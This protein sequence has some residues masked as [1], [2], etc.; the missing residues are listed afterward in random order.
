MASSNGTVST[1][2]VSCLRSFKN[3]LAPIKESSFATIEVPLIRWEDELGRLRVLAANMG[4]HQTGQ[5]SLDFRL[6]DASHISKLIIKLLDGLETTI[7]DVKVVL[8]EGNA[9]GNNPEMY[10]SVEDDSSTELQ[11]LHG[12]ILTII[13]ELFQTS[14][15]IRKPARHDFMTK[16]RLDDVKAFEPF[17]WEHVRN[18]LPEAD[19]EIIQ[20]VGYAITRR[21]G[22]LKYRERHHAKLGKGLS[23][24]GDQSEMSETTAT[25]FQAKNIDFEETNS[26]S[27]ISETSSS[28][29]LVDGGNFTIPQPSSESTNGKPFECPYCFFVIT[30]SGTR[31][32]TK[33]IFKD[34]QPYICTFQPCSRPDKLYDSRREWFHHIS[35][36][37]SRSLEESVVDSKH[38]CSLCKNPIASLKRL[39]RH[40]ARHL[41]ELALFALPKNE[42]I[43]DESDSKGGPDQKD[44]E[45]YQKSSA[46]IS[47]HEI[48][49]DSIDDLHNP[50]SWPSPRS[51]TDFRESGFSGGK[52]GFT[53]SGHSEGF[54]PLTTGYRHEDD[55]HDLHAGLLDKY[56]PTEAVS[57]EGYI[58]TKLMQ[59]PGEGETWGR[60]LR[61]PMNLSQKELFAEAKRRKNKWPS[62]AKMIGFKQ[63]QIDL[64]IDERTRTDNDLGFEYTLA[65]LKLNLNLNDKGQPVTESMEVILKRSLRPD[66]IHAATMIGR[67]E[68]SVE[69]EGSVKAEGSVEIVDLTTRPFD[70]AWSTQNIRP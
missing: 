57:Y 45:K 67:A 46:S 18:K 22:Y 27:G 20:R 36:D 4:A 50:S 25:E 59:S 43:H 37:H 62:Q 66:V 2:L 31:S 33:H 19:R 34:L 53:T 54:L 13:S 40:V 29:S 16:S 47:S 3:L 68:G 28:P 30:I 39:E 51:M 48:G 5:A 8:N 44:I 1:A 7:E 60:V 42:D 63:R 10:S 56:N 21:R 9:A 23:D 49:D 15:L 55:T 61:K 35:T 6:R 69:A 24:I 12:Q 14:M 58:Y 26:N 17:D 32:W 41:E 52:S 65:S 38:V 70:D 64:L 11:E